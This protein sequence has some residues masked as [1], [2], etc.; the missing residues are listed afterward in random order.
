MTPRTPKLD[1]TRVVLC[2]ADGTLFPSEEPAFVASAKVTR[3]LAESYGVAGDFSPE[4]LRRGTTGRNFRTTAGALLAEAGVTLDSTELEEWV[5]RE[6]KVVTEYLSTALDVTPDVVRAIV[7]L[8]SRFTLA[9]V[10]S[11][12]LVRLDACFIATGLAK[13]FPIGCRFSAEDSLPRPTSKP[14]PAVYR[15]AL[16]ALACPAGAAVAIEDSTI[17]ARSAVAAGIP[18]LGLV[19]FVPSDERVDRKRELLAHGV[20]AVADSWEETVAWLTAR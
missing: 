10:S 3:A 5:V 11:S 8:A 7:T 16:A 9:A 6:R 20:L 2:D 14:D 13:W 4:N 19:Q 15:H 17:G 12:A 18:T 1:G